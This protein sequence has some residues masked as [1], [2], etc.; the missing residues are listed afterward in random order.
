MS[1]RDYYEVLGV[2]RDAGDPDIKKAFRACAMKFHPDRN[3]GDKAAEESFKEA[4]EA[5]D[6]LSDAD[7]RARYDRYGHQGMQ[8]AAGGAGQYGNMDDL[9]SHFGD[10]FGDI[11]GGSGRSGRQRPSR[12]ADLRYDLGISLEEAYSG[13]RKEL[14]IPRVEPCET[15]H[16]SGAK[17]GTAPEQC[18]KC[19]GRGQVSTRQGPF[20]FAVSCPS[21]GG[22][23]T[24][25][26]PAN[27]CGDCGGSG[28]THIERKVGVK[29]PPGVDTGTRL[30]VGGE[31]EK[32]PAGQPAGDL[33]V[34]LQVAGHEFFQRQ[35]DDL[36]C[37]VD[38]EVPT[39]VL[40][41][42]VDVPLIDGTRE[43][44][45]LPAG[46]Q[47]GERVRLR[48]KGIPHLS[49]SGRGDQIAHVKLVVPRQLSKEQKELY[50]R[51]AALTPGA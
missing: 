26:K 39:A 12:G 14:T 37:E 35:D 49:G 15:C 43:K 25:I 50:E 19:H 27:R 20:M 32:G 13:I 47:P 5:Y 3:P 42:L 17:T 34:V 18:S 24:T 6:V 48:G 22:Q 40:G 4:A 10:I 44:V 31:G 9:F 2:A 30:R 7:K 46:V 45:K 38:V 33:Y 16:G 8:G 11:F 1:K 41:G 51:L 23:G 36:H 28:S 29:V 21:C